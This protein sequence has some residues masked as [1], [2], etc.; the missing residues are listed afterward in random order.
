MMTCFGVGCI[1]DFGIRRSDFQH[2]SLEGASD[3]GFE[4]GGLH[5]PIFGGSLE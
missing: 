4:L 5:S 3:P 1:S 2:G